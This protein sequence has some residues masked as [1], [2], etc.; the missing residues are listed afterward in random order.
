LPDKSF[1]LET[2]GLPRLG[3]SWRGGFK[4]LSVSFDA[5]P[6]AE[7]EDAKE[8]K[9]GRRVALPDGSTL[10]VRVASPFLL[11]ELLLT[12][13][14]E[15]VPGSSGDPAVRH[16]VAWQ[17]IAAVAV[18][19][20]VIGLL[21]KATG[22]D[23]LR[24]IGAG[25][26]SVFAGLVYGVLAWLVRGRSIVALGIAIA[27][28]ALDGV[29]VLVSAAQA[30]SNPVS[31]LIVRLFLLIPMLRWVPALREIDRKPLRRRSGSSRG[32]SRSSTPACG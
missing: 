25:W 26:P 20:V 30:G 16:A 5:Q 22:A 23:F 3:V 14:G 27:L 10:E 24:G 13:D 31:G 7:F 1:P 2:G 19:N 15:P 18:L 9:E 12:R 11:P 29:F 28:F 6:V 21:V 8:L 32:G 17:V 4:D